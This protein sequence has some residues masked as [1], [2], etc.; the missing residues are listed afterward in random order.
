VKV[1]LSKYKPRIQNSRVLTEP[2]TN[3]HKAQDFYKVID[4]PDEKTILLDNGNLV[5]FLGVLIDNGDEARKY[6]QDYLLGKTVMLKETRETDKNGLVSGYV[7]LKNKIFINAYLIKSG[8]ASP[9][10]QVDHRYA[11]KFRRW[12]EEAGKHPHS[13]AN[14]SDCQK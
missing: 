12:A 8:L 9:D 11:N 3:H 4:I 6:L 14:F 5:N 13:L 7:Y 10:D 1:P 2:A